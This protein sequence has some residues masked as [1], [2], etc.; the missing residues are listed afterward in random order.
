VLL[1]CFGLP[2]FAQPGLNIQNRIISSVQTRVKG[3]VDSFKGSESLRRA[4]KE[5]KSKNTGKEKQPLTSQRELK[6]V[7]RK[8]RP[9]MIS[10][11]ADFSGN[12][13]SRNF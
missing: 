9:G 5:I 7:S 6:A 3:N 10:R 1:L 12:P 4:P 2:A 11:F 8:M 13:L